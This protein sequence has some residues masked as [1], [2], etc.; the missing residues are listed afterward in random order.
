MKKKRILRGIFGPKRD[1]NGEWRL[2]HNELLHSLYRS[3][4]IVRAIES[5]RLSWARHVARMEE[6]R[7]AFKM[8]TSNS[9]G[10]TD[11]GR[12]GRRW[13]GNIRMYILKKWCQYEALD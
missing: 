13:K 2:L 7:N 5:R 10:N 1:N 8:L 6:G 4:N 12:P 11:L 9:T 3:P